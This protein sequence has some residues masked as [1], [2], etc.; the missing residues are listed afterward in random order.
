MAILAPDALVRRLT[1]SS[2]GRDV[3]PGDIGRI[4]QFFGPGKYFPT[5]WIRTDLWSML[6]PDDLDQVYQLVDENED[7]DADTAMNPAA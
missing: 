6:H 3:Q 7:A 2:T 4:D 1:P 5:N